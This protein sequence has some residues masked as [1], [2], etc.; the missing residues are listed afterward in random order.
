MENTGWPHLLPTS[1]P[2]SGRL[3]LLPPAHLEKGAKGGRTAMGPQ[4]LRASRSGVTRWSPALGVVICKRMISSIFKLQAKGD[5][6]EFLGEKL[7]LSLCVSTQEH[8]LPGVSLQCDTQTHRP[9][10][11]ALICSLFESSWHCN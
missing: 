10:L 8:S 9:H 3:S 5:T 2:H 11:S 1:Y 6:E 4:Y 7:P